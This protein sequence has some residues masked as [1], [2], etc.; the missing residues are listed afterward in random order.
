MK[1]LLFSVISFQ[2]LLGAINQGRT[3]RLMRPR[4]GTKFPAQFFAMSQAK[5][6]EIWSWGVLKK[7]MSPKTL[8]LT[9][10]KSGTSVLGSLEKRWIHWNYRWTRKLLKE[11]RPTRVQIG[12]HYQHTKAK[13]PWHW[14]MDVAHS[15]KASLE[16]QAWLFLKFFSEICV[17]PVSWAR[18]RG[19]HPMKTKIRQ[20]SVKG[21]DKHPSKNTN[22]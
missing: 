16:W 7:R 12:S 18:Y 1:S 19:W 17:F 21:R 9:A 5:S 4:M 15:Q 22:N 3:V 13:W 6:L 8:K 10:V 2:Y 14:W 11:T 20:K